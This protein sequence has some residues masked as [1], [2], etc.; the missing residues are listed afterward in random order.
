M[1][2]TIKAAWDYYCQNWFPYTIP[3]IIIFVIT[4]KLWS[5]WK[6]FKERGMRDIIRGLIASSACFIFVSFYCVIK[7]SDQLVSDKDNQISQLKSGHCLSGSI[8]EIKF[9]NDGG[10]LIVASVRN[11][12]APSIAENFS[13]V[14]KTV[15]GKE[16]AGRG[17]MFDR[18]GEKDF[19][20]SDGNTITIDT[21]TDGLQ[22][23]CMT[24]IP[25]G[26]MSRGYLCFGF[27]KSFTFGPGTIF[28]LSF[29]DIDGK[30][31]QAKYIASGYTVG[32]SW[33]YFSGL[34]MPNIHK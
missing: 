20:W 25:Q 21:Y 22:N 11:N 27:E 6:R 26:G 1:S 5:L 28:T 7:S 14:V 8:D 33:N 32:G 23:K 9:T 12:G 16:I 13:L 2:P 29:T 17:L 30:Q 3:D 4:A 10:A 15:D 31:Y 24:P 34:K 19:P 18:A